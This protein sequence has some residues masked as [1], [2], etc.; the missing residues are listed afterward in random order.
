[1]KFFLYTMFGSLFMLV[2]VIALYF[3]HG[4][5]AGAFT[6]DYLPADPGRHGGGALRAAAGP[7]DPAL[8][9]AF[10]IAFA[11]KQPLFPFHTWSF[12]AHIEAPTAGSVVLAA[13]F[14][15]DGHLR[16]PALLLA[17]LPRGQRHSRPRVCVP[18]LVGIIYGAL[19][20]MVQ[21][22]LKRL[23]AYRR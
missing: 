1:M 13:V 12:D 10:G 20:C 2:A 4:Q 16:L 9:L 18:A 21:P 15:E 7:P 8:F 11:I 5:A 22:D 6:F 14:P 17:A 3:W 19:V 23:V